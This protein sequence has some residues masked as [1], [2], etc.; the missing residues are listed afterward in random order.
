MLVT[1]SRRS[2]T[3]IDV[4]AVFSRTGRAEAFALK[5][6]VAVVSSGSL[7]SAVAASD[8]VITC[9]VAPTVILGAQ[10]VLDALA[11]RGESGFARTSGTSGTSGEQLI[12]DLGLPRNVDPA[13]ADITGVELLDLETKLGAAVPGGDQPL[14]DAHTPADFLMWHSD[15]WTRGGRSRLIDTQQAFSERVKNKQYLEW[16]FDSQQAEM[17]GNVAVTF[18][19]YTATLRGS[20]PDRAWFAV[21]Y[22]RIY[23]KQNGVWMLLSQRTVHGA[24]YGPTR[25]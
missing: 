24:T 17:H 19:R 14:F 9:S 7:T 25:E 15:P 11:M 4:N 18:G 1:S 13:V 10:T 2:A 6:C 23:R 12:I 21:W 20:D 5:H 16:H 3:R 8:L 22:E